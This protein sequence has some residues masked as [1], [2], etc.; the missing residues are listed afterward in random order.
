MHLNIF[1]LIILV[2]SFSSSA[3]TW[4]LCHEDK[5][6]PPYIASEAQ[7]SASS[8]LLVDILERAASESNIELYFTALPWK[9]CK[10]AVKD[11]TYDG[12]FAMIKTP[13]RTK[14]FAFPTNQKDY[15]NTADYVILYKRDSIL[16]KAELAGKL[17]T[18]KGEFNVAYYKKIKQFGLQAPA[19][20][21]LEQY[22]KQHNIAANTDYDLNLGIHQV[23]IGR[24]DGYLV[25]KRIGLAQVKALKQQDF[26]I[27]SQ[28]VI[29]KTHWYLPFNLDF[30]LQN[31]TEVTRFWQQI[32]KAREYILKND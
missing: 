9:R 23:A 1:L 22:I 2:V 18:D 25:E 31:K 28:G 16:H 11:G 13:E 24:L 8:G 10:Q 21:V 4:R 19:G 26:V 5:Q 14:Q 27:S 17:F 30:Y 7:S 20:Y 15:L 32:Q 29:R 3:K 6:Y 12:L